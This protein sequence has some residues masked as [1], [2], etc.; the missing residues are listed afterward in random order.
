M[1]LHLHIWAVSDFRRKLTLTTEPV[2]KLDK[3]KTAT[4]KKL[5]KT[6]CWQVTTSLSFF[7]L[8]V[9]LDQ[10]KYFRP[11]QAATGGVLWKDCSY[12]YH[13]IHK[14]RP[15]SFRSLFFAGLVSSKLKIRTPEWQHWHRSLV[16]IVNFEQIRQLH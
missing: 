2:I 12:K 13:R 6:L 7:R 15:A 1:I 4:L 8:I 3:R 16:S 9:N 5:T 11:S 14:K 10:F